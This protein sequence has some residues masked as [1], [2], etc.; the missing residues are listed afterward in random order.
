MYTLNF[1]IECQI[2]LAHQLCC[3]WHRSAGSIY[4]KIKYDLNFV[5]L[6]WNQFSIPELSLNAFVHKKCCELLHNLIS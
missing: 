1:N 3:N 4:L 2:R 5:R 6:R